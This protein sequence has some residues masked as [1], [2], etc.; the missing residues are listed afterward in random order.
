[1]VAEK[2]KATLIANAKTKRLFAK[3]LKQ[4]NL[5][6]ERLNRSSKGKGNTLAEDAPGSDDDMTGDEEGS[7][8]DEDE[9]EEN[10]DE[11]EKIRTQG[12]VSSLSSKPKT[13][14]YVHPSRRSAST[15]ALAS[16][17]SARGWAASARGT[18]RGRGSPGR[19]NIHGGGKERQPHMGDKMD[20][21]LAK[22]RK[23]MGEA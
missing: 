6:S 17:S 8:D 15:G 2:I 5:T 9:D 11:E 21:M 4:E 7:S 20:A 22:I 13:T 18:T 12:L 14:Q 10:N 3:T 16:T 1:L 19:G 23:G